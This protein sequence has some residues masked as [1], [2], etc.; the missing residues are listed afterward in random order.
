MKPEF[1]ELAKYRL[2]RASETLEEFDVL[3]A[4]NKKYA[5][6]NRLY[7]AVFYC[8]RALLATNGL[9]SSKHKGVISFFNKEFVKTGQ[10]SKEKASVVKEAYR[11]RTEGDYSDF[12]EIDE[13]ELIEIGN[14]TK[15]F[16][17]ETKKILNQLGI[18]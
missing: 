16:I 5:A 13:K 9:D 11:I 12:T 4:S 3:M 8:M 6:A 15:D 1:Q 7:Y 10:F 14:Q 17:A 18:K 2:E